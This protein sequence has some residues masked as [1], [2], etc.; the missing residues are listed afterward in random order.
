[1]LFINTSASLKL[2][3]ALFSIRLHFLLDLPCKITCCRAD[4]IGSSMESS[5][6]IIYNLSN[7]R[8][9]G[10]GK[11]LGTGIEIVPQF[12]GYHQPAIFVSGKKEQKIGRA[13]CREED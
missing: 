4:L 5:L 11:Y 1:M 3:P 2:Y 7:L 8:I 12:C 6:C 13:Q 10:Y 9:G